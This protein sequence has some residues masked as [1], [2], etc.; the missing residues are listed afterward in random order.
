MMKAPIM[1]FFIN[2]YTSDTQHL[3]TEQ[4]GAYLLLLFRIWSSDC[5]PLP[6][7][8]V[9]LSRATKLSMHKW[10]KHKKILQE[11]FKVE[12]NYWKHNRLEREWIKVI[13]KINSKGVFMRDLVESNRRRSNQQHRQMTGKELKEFNEIMKN[14]KNNPLIYKESRSPHKTKQ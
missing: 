1:P 8:D 2:L 6:D 11:F 3:T 10:L 7:D 12:N 9:V 13:N 4:H 5:R 14:F